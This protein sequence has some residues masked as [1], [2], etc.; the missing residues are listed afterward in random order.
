M[1]ATLLTIQEASK[2]SGKSTQ[3]IRRLLKN[4]KIKC[5]KQRTPQGFNY[6][7]DRDSLAKY[8]GLNIEEIKE[9]KKATKAEDVFEL[10]V[11][12]DTV[13]SKRK[14]KSVLNE[15]PIPM[16]DLETFVKVGVVGKKGKVSADADVGITIEETVDAAETIEGEIAEDKVSKKTSSSNE[17]LQF[18]AILQQMMK[19]HEEDKDRLFALV[20]QF[21]KRT[22]ILEERLKKLEAPKKKWWKIF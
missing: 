15:Q 17:T 20:E 2:F 3:T 19:Q 4:N 18:A 22:I 10:G 12:P 14:K 11:E 8:F 21:Q 7:L 1:A 13:R 16:E 6:Q 5:R 9:T